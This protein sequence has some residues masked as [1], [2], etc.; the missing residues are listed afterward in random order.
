MSAYYYIC[1]LI[2]VPEVRTCI[3][4]VAF[5]S[6]FFCL[7]KKNRCVLIQV[8]EVRPC[9]LLLGGLR[10]AAADAGT[11]CTCYTGTQ[12][13]WYKS[14]NTDLRLAA[15]DGGAQF[16]CVTGTKVQILLVQKCKY[17][18]RLAAAGGEPTVLSLLALLV[19]KILVQKYKC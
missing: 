4:L 5:F 13:Y 16:T 19:K 3:L 1:V 9:I 8:P 7:I 2:Q 11:Q 15:A 12:V 17:Y 10:L 14:A 18:L 6:E